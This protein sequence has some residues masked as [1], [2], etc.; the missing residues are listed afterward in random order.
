MTLCNSLPTQLIAGDS[1]NGTLTFANYPATDW[2]LNYYL[3]GRTVLQVTGVAS[4]LDHS[5]IISPAKTSTLVGGTYNYSVTMTSATERHT[6]ATGFVTIKDNPATSGQ[7]IAHAEKMFYAIEA[8]LD[9]RITDDVQQV[10]IAGRSITNI[11]VAELF[12]YRAMY[13]RELDRIQNNNRP[14]NRT[15]PI[16]FG[17]RRM[18]G[19]LGWELFP[20]RVPEA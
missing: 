16:S 11:P 5:L 9:G 13:A 8:V 18:S 3:Q 4:G 6:V 15:I 20:N 2:T 7:K 12:V 10:S 17:P 19:E 1:Y 14:R